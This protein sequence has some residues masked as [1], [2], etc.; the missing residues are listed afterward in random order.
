M[1]SYYYSVGSY[2]AALKEYRRAYELN[3]D[4]PE[5]LER[6]RLTERTMAGG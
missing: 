5:N 3:P 6:I 2:E 4:D 1:G